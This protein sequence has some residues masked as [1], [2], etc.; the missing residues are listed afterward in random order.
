MKAN[1][2]HYIVCYPDIEC[3]REVQKTEYITMVEGSTAQQAADVVAKINRKT[4]L[5]CE[6]RKDSM[7]GQEY[8]GKYIGEM[9]EQERR[10]QNMM[11]EWLKGGVER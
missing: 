3:G 1:T 4:S 11:F 10:K 2:V 8:C 5:H 6:V 7:F 9:S